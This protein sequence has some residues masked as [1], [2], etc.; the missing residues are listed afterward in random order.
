LEQVQVCLLKSILKKEEVTLVTCLDKYT[1]QLPLLDKVI[2]TDWVCPQ[3]LPD[4]LFDTVISTE[5]IEHI[6]R[7]QFEPLLE[8]IKKCTQRRWSIRRKYTKQTSTNY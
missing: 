3:E 1:E 7:D 2:R 8:D 4:E 5:F 6:E